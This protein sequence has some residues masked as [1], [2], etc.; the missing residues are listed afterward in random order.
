MTQ[1]IHEHSARVRSENGT[2]YRARIFGEPRSDGTWAGWL[3]FVPAA[4]SAAPT[5]KTEQET[6]QPDR[7]AVEYWAGGLEP[8][9]LEGALARARP[10][11]GSVRRDD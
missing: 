5:L 1:L 11:R 2:E 7:Q 4:D 3:E 10:S 9:Y 8:V 6:S